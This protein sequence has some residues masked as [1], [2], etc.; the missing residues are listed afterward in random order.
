MN[1]LTEWKAQYA[2]DYERVNLAMLWPGT[3]ANP[4]IGC[5]EKASLDGL[6]TLLSN[7]DLI[8]AMHPDKE[9]NKTRPSDYLLPL[10]AWAHEVKRPSLAPISP[11]QPAIPFDG[12]VRRRK[13]F[14]P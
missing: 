7:P 6:N 14:R 8:R 2:E 10:G 9:V 4:K 3:I 13:A 11:E 5:L 12:I 1:L